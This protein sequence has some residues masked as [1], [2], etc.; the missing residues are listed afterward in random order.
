MIQYLIL[1]VGVLLVLSNINVSGIGRAAINFG[2]SVKNV[3]SRIPAPHMPDIKIPQVNFPVNHEHGLVELVQQWETLKQS[4]I[5]NNLTDAVKKLDEIFPTL[6][7]PQ[8]KESVSN[9]K[10]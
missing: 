1:A 6:I 3:F 2:N 9:E 7:K 8:E 5:D 10:S 4:C